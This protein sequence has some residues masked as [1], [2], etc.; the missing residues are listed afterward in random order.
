MTARVRA[1]S[2]AVWVRSELE[3]PP[4]SNRT[5]LRREVV[6]SYQLH[7]K[8]EASLFGASSPQ[9]ERAVV[10]EFGRDPRTQD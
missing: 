8:A 9:A 4:P 7:R 3:K 10:P 1:W 6:C 2:S 5:F